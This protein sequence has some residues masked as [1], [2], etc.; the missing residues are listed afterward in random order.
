MPRLQFSL[1]RLMATTAAFAF[2]FA[3][4]GVVAGSVVGAVGV[5]VSAGLVPRRWQTWEAAAAAAWLAGAALAFSHTN[6]G[7]DAETLVLYTFSGCVLGVSWLTREI[8]GYLQPRSRG[9]RAASLFVLVAGLLGALCMATDWD[10]RFRLAASER[11]LLAEAQSLPAAYNEMPG[12]TR[13]LGLFVVRRLQKQP[14]GV[15]WTTDNRFPAFGVAYLSG[16]VPAP[17]RRH[18]FRHLWGP[19]WTFR[20]DH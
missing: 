19:W 20:F 4:F 8:V 6:L 15:L 12:K 7:G 14:A 18:R 17:W 10:L 2:V 1:R 13:R 5:A 11:A 16:P 3:L 9:E